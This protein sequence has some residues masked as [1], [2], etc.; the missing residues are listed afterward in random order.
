VV[1][2]GTA[3]T[4]AAQ[5]AIPGAPAQPFQ[6]G[7]ETIVI[8]A[9]RTE[10]QLS[11]APAAMTV[12]SASEIGLSAADDYGDLLRNVP[13]LNVAQTSVR[14]INMTARGSTSILANSQLVMLDG[15]SI[16]LDFFGFV[17]WDLLPIQ[18]DEVERIEV[19]RGPGSAIWGANAMTGV[20]NII[21]KR[22]KDIAGT[23]IVVGTPY[24]S[25]VHAAVADAFS[26]K[27]S[28]GYFEQPAYDRPTGVIPGSVPPQ[29]YPTFENE[30]T[31]QQR[32]NF[33]L[34]WGLAERGSISLSG[35]YAAT[36]GILHSG[37]GPFDIASGSNVS[38]IKADWNDGAL[39]V[40]V[41][42][43]FL[44]GDA[45]NLL[46][47]AGDGGPL[48]FSFVTDTYHL[49]A[50]NTSQVGERH[51][52]TY[53]AD[54]RTNDFALGIAPAASD[55]DE[56]GIFLQDEI[57]LGERVRWVVGARY[58]DVDPLAD[59]VFT[60]RTSLLIS[61]SPTHTFRV[62]YNG[63]FRTP[64]VVNGYLDVTVLQNVGPFLLPSE[65]D[66]NAMLA[67]ERLRPTRSA[68]SARSRTA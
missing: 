62:S 4:A 29:S 11:T 61:A 54:V 65:A 44:D 24:A 56:N 55:K 30:G 10:Q 37:I 12:I 63:A 19:V 49:T 46:T 26:Y 5:R 14:D 41:D 13:G 45:V 64:S 28:A 18:A 35:G 21:G 40:G 15:R 38:Y 48:S 8:T 39:H 43:D 34:E 50:P 1:L 33:E 66:G 22:P 25:V 53:G 9:S 7:L 27:L 47:L 20:V 32:A 67:E 58:D 52:L 6:G 31:R 60:P 36:D 17:M 59:A 2:L 68:T 23:T 57:R 51:V 16:Y 3:V 42:A